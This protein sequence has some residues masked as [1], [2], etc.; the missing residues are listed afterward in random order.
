MPG[1]TPIINGIN[2]AWA[3]VSVI[4]FGQPIIGIV[5][6]EYK[7]KQ[8]KTNNYGAGVEPVS[9][10]L[11]MKEYEGSIEIYTDVWKA[12][13]AG[14]PN[15]DPLNIPMFDIPVTFSGDGVVT[16]KDVLRAVEFMEDPLSTKSGDD[17]MTV[18]IPLIIGGIDR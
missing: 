9:R 16:T 11:G 2:Y 8:K 18:K 1:N 5:A 15:R 13:I 7:R 4:L 3:N 12:I 6:I 14:A 10:G 17:K